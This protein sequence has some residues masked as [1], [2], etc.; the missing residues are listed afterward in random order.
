MCHNLSNSIDALYWH[1]LNLMMS[2]GLAIVRTQNSH[3]PY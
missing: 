1:L 2:E 3:I